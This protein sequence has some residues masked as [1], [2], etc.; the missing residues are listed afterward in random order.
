MVGFVPSHTHT[1]THIIFLLHYFVINK[2]QNIFY[3][4]HSSI[5]FVHITFHINTTSLFYKYAINEHRGNL[6][7]DI[8]FIFDKDICIG[9]FDTNEDVDN[10]ILLELVEQ[11]EKQFFPIMS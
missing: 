9:D 3:S 7:D 8:G 1:H 2:A 5:P 10:C 4:S 6:V 11:E